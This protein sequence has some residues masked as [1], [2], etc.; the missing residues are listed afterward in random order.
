MSDRSICSFYQKIGAC[1]HGDKCS[2]R[3]VKPTESKT[4]LLSNLYEDPKKSDPKAEPLLASDFDQF[5]A[6]VFIKVALQGEVESIVVCENENFHLSGNVYVRFTS[7]AAANNA[8]MAL[9]QE[10]FG[11]RPVYCDLL[12]VASFHEANCRAHDTNSCNRGGLCNFMH[13]RRPSNEM[14][15]KLKLAQDKSIALAEIRKIKGADWG[16]EWEAPTKNPYV[17][18]KKK[19]EEAPIKEAVEANDKKAEEPVP[20]LKINAVAKLFGSS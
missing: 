5:Y 4:I 13:V 15:K 12:P 3:H 19:K 20:V 11:G 7:M 10:W 1:R 2:R 18:D 14:R 17:K 9:N 16:H 6:D 8:V